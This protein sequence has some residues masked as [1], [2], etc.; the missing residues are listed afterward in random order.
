MES[1]QFYHYLELVSRFW[2]WF[3]VFW[4]LSS[5]IKDCVVS[6]SVFIS[7][8]TLTTALASSEYLNESEQKLPALS[9]WYKSGQEHR[10]RDYIRGKKEEN[11]ISKISV[12]FI[13][14][15]YHFPQID[16]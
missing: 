15:K 7:S 12:L 8:N 2:F 3:L 13:Q 5:T 11:S 14:G 4:H 6:Y 10:W 9:S 16:V 1:N